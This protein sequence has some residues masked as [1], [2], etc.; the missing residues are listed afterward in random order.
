MCRKSQLPS[1]SIQDSTDS[2]EAGSFSSPHRSVVQRSLGSWASG[3]APRHPWASREAT[4]I[5][6]CVD[7]PGKDGDWIRVAEF[8]STKLVETSN[9]KAHKTG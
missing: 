2:V 5:L 4:K 9:V 3:L 8:T 1:G 7:W 6:L